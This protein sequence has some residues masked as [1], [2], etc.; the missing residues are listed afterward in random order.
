MAFKVLQSK[1]PGLSLILVSRHCTRQSPA[2]SG[3][4]CTIHYWFKMS[5]HCYATQWNRI[6]QIILVNICTVFLIL[7]CKLNLELILQNQSISWGHL[8]IV[9]NVL[10]LTFQT[11]ILLKW[12]L[13]FV[14]KFYPILISNI[15]NIL[16]FIVNLIIPILLRKKWLL[17]VEQTGFIYT[18][19]DFM[20][21][22]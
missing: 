11:I 2:V 17:R 13:H 7:I 10:S 18:L 8:I 4:I 5:L 21:I 19:S 9:K 6:N 20:I 16:G 15:A 1:Q 3:S 14:L 12:S 22:V